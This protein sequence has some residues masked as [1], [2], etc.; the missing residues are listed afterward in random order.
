MAQEASHEGPSPPAA[1]R[2]RATPY[3]ASGEACLG[4][5][6]LVVFWLDSTIPVQEA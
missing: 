6:S 4:E 3:A 2:T 1:C 5:T